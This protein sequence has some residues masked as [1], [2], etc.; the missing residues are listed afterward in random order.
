MWYLKST[1]KRLVNQKGDICIGFVR[2]VQ[3]IYIEAIY[4]IGCASSL[5]SCATTTTTF[6]KTCSFN[7]LSISITR[8]QID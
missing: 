1:N 5:V 6:V 7:R 4:D 8:Y 3:D 2:D